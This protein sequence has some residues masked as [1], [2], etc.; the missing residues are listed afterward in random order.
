MI[1][2][3]TQVLFCYGKYPILILMKTPIVKPVALKRYLYS[4]S[5]YYPTYILFTL[6][7]NLRTAKEQNLPEAGKLYKGL[8]RN[9]GPLHPDLGEKIHGAR[10]YINK[11]N[12][13]LKLLRRNG[14]P[15][16]INIRGYP[17]QSIIGLNLCRM[18]TLSRKMIARKFRKL[19][20]GKGVKIDPLGL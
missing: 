10:D 19:L 13:T 16:Q 18:L 8:D 4:W 20:R 11:R 2:E 5:L 6:C 17:P 7:R 14:A 12:D 3:K 9:Y 1:F 15:S